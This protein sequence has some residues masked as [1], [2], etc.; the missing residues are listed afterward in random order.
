MSQPT[1]R[2]LTVLEL[3]Q[4]RRHV[5]GA[6]LA[7][8][9]GVDRRTVRRYIT[10]LEAIGVPI[11]TEQGPHGGYMLVPGFKL[12]P[13]MFT[14]AEVLALSVGL[15]ASRGVGL[16]GSAPATTSAQAKLER[17]MP[18]NLRQRLSAV[19]ETVA[20]DLSKPAA[21]LNA[22]VLASVSSAAQM[23]M[24]VALTYRTPR[25]E[26]TE[27]QFDPYGLAYRGGR[28]FTVGLCHLRGGLRSFRLDRIQAV[29]HSTIHFTR[30]DS[31]DTVRHL[32]QSLA[33]IPRAHSVEVL[34]QA[35]LESAQRRLF[36]AFGALE[37]VNGGVLLRSE[38]DDLDW[39]A[40]ELAR[41][42]FQFEVL[43]PAAL[44]HAIRRV[45][46]RLAQAVEPGM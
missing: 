2:V 20:L 37:C 10:R 43:R 44:S 16:A 21:T 9:L 30:P 17:V 42:P 31:F 39:F 45:A 36:T 4:S 8:L 15:V 40:R 24:R 25:G 6:E 34:L 13:M 46:A 28:W 11:T 5:S 29:R 33:L 14:D 7:A 41:L 26:E 12:P 23:R 19:I 27:R 38:V 18:A 3:L 22:S 1:L 35:D 32:K